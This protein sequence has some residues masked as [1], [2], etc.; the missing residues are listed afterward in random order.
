MYL[1]NK[2]TYKHRRVKYD[3]HVT[4][5]NTHEHIPHFMRLYK[6]IIK[7]RMSE[8]GAQ[9][10]GKGNLYLCIIFSSF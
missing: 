1:S 3:T 6:S 7:G 9:I 5:F 8:Q 10:G 4:Q 2:S